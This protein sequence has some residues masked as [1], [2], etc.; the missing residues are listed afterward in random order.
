MNQLSDIII[1]A[2]S[3]IGLIN[4]LMINYCKK[5]GIPVY[6]IINGLIANSFLDEAKEGTWIN[7]Y[8]ASIRDNYFKGMKNIICLGDPRMDKYSIRSRKK[9]LGNA[10]ITIGIGASG[11]ANIDLNCYLAIEFEFLN[12]I[13]KACRELKKIG[14]EM[15]IIIKTRQNNYIHQYQCFLSEYYPDIPVTIL[16]NVPM[17]QIYGRIDFYISTTSQT[18]FE[19]SCQGIPV[20]YYKN[21]THCYHPPFDGESELVTAFDLE[22]LT[23]KIEAFYNG[24]SIYNAFKEKKN[25]EKYIGPLD[26]QNL[27]RNMEFIY[28]IVASGKDYGNL[29]LQ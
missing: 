9:P 15:E 18:L 25:L 1:M 28:K 11:F 2:I 6:M 10:K 21:D 19:A 12:D 27:R 13:L 26:G 24:D 14:R 20:L 17:M 7:S 29:A 4:R 3:S 22:D 23:R 5:N 16:H 8:G